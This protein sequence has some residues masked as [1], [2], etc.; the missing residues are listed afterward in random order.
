M[1]FRKNSRTISVILSL[2]VICSTCEMCNSH[3]CRVRAKSTFVS[4]DRNPHL[5]EHGGQ[6]GVRNTAA[7]EY[8]EA[9]MFSCA[10]MA[11]T[12]AHHTLY[13]L[14][15]CTYAHHAQC[16]PCTSRPI[17]PFGAFSRGRECARL[18][19]CRGVGDNWF[20]GLGLGL[21][22]SLALSLGLGRRCFGVE[23]SKHFFRSNS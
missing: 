3:P 15:N 23:H 19:W 6:R 18:G 4:L 10:H 1:T 21:G 14:C 16:K 22:L 12:A 13:T 5:F 17:I 9:V 2:A 11:T 20:L 8:A 7:K